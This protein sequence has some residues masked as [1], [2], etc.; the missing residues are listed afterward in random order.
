M[1]PWIRA[2][3]GNQPCG[4]KQGVQNSAGHWNCRGV[5]NREIHLSPRN[6]FC[7]QLPSEFLGLPD[8]FKLI[9]VY[10]KALEL[11]HLISAH[12]VLMHC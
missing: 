7:E 5:P 12:E 10:W 6:I 4:A 9:V 11:E 3:N 8:L 1:Q 2:V